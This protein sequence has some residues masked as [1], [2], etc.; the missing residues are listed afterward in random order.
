[1]ILGHSKILGALWLALAALVCM[2]GF[3]W[4]Q[5][6]WAPSVVAFPGL[7]LRAAPRSYAVYPKQELPLKFSHKVHMSKGMSCGS[8]HKNVEKSENTADDLLPPGQ[9]CDACHGAQHPPPPKVKRNCGMCHELNA[10]KLVAKSVHIPPARL[11]FSHKA[12]KDTPCARCHGDLSQVDLATRDHLPTEANCLECHDGKTQSNSC[13]LCHPQDGSGRL[14]TDAQRSE[15]M[16]ALMPRGS[17]R[18]PLTHDLRFVYDHAAIALA[19]RDQCMSCHAESFCSDCHGNGMRPLQIHPPG[20]LGTHGMQAKTNTDTCMN[21]HQRATDCR[22]CHLRFGVSDNLSLGRHAGQA[23][24]T[25]LKF[26]PPG[27]ATPSGEQLHASDA[28]KN[29]N[30][31]ASCHS[32]DTCLSCHATSQVARPGLS[33]NPHGANF[34]Q[35]GRCNALARNNRRVCLKC[36]APGVPAL[37]CQG[38]EL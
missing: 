14:R 2:A 17:R 36:H 37:D 4:S 25:R 10:R 11:R 32:E 1:M 28:R 12:H 27:Y 8:C 6:S 16:A 5:S 24:P 31:C 19:Q 21:C 9:T 22:A 23:V 35:S 29:I 3:R 7:K 26:H 13:Q 38:R 30:A 20:F 18:G 33:A 15:G 34:V